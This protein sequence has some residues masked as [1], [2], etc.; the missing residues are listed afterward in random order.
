MTI[1]I[2]KW[3]LL[4]VLAVVV[5]AGVGVGGYLLGQESRSDD[6]HDAA[7]LSKQNAAFKD[8]VR[9]F[10]ARLDGMHRRLCRQIVRLPNRTAPRHGFTEA[11]YCRTPT[12]EP[13]KGYT[14]DIIDDRMTNWVSRMCGVV[15]IALASLENEDNCVSG[16][17]LLTRDE[18]AF[19]ELEEFDIE[20]GQP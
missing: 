18:K 16:L 2:P 15:Q 4:I 5:M 9:T 8:D 1:R 17:P 12:S 10:G 20:A 19:N 13:K 11:D 6:V 7:V 3:F 14:L